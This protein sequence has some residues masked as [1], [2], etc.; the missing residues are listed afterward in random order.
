MEEEILQQLIDGQN[1]I[2][3]RVSNIQGGG[4]MD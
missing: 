3:Y 4:M 2:I 1:P